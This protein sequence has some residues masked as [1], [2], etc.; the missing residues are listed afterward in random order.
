MMKRL[1][2]LLVALFVAVTSV[3]YVCA[4]DYPARPVQIVVPYS[5]GGG[6]D[7]STRVMAD[8]IK[9]YLGSTMVVLDKPGGGGSI[10]TSFVAHSKPDGYT[11]GMGAQGP[12]AMLPHF[13]GI[14]YNKDS[15]DFIALQARNLMAIAVG[16]DSPITDGKSFVEYAKANPGKV[17]VGMSGAAGAS[18]IATEGFAAKAGIELKAMPFKGSAPAVTACVGGHI[19]AVTASPAE[20]VNHANA[21]NVKILFVMEEKRL[22]MLPE[23]PTT[24]E[25]GVDFQWASWKGIIAPKGLPAD[26]KAKLADALDKTFK[27]PEYLEKMKNLGEFVDYRDGAAYQALVNNDSKIA[28]G[29]IRS[30]G[31]YGMNDK[32]K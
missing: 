4:A 29:V 32:K 30:L 24:K 28:E 12:L 2:L 18:R 14:D 7:V 9:K 1:S 16:K 22:E 20:L 8:V 10:G 13:G 31:M 17:T 6:T 11:L 23:V 19:M 25:I 26:V 5:A 21:G 27:D 15:Y 3:S